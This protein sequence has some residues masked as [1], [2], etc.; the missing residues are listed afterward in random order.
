MAL[1]GTLLITGI[2]PAVALSRAVA[3]LVIAYP[4][5]MGLATPTV[6]LVATGTAALQGTLVRDAAALETVGR[7]DA[8]LLDKTGTLTTGRP[9]VVDVFDESTG[10]AT[11]DELARLPTVIG[12]ARRSVRIIKQNLFWAFFYNLAAI[13]LAATGKIRPGIAAAAMMCSSISVVLNSLR[14]RTR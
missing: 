6:V 3:V 12:L 1:A 9:A 7:I 14:L 4:C 2:E 5:A 13:P 8:M 10:P 11:H